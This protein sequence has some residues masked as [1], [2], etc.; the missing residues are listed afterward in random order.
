M[1]IW[2]CT[3]CDRCKKAVMVMVMKASDGVWIS[4]AKVKV[5][6]KRPAPEPI[7]SYGGSLQQLR[8]AMFICSHKTRRESQL[9]D[10]GTGE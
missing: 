6:A 8:V 3:G 10:K 5:T 4:V 1:R 2:L 7:R 9:L